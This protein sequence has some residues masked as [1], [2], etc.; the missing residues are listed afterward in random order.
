MRDPHVQSMH[1][2]IGSGEGISYQDPESMT[3]SNH[4]GSFEIT[5]NALSIIP[6]E[7]FDE[8]EEA[9]RAIEPFLRSWE[10]EADLKMNLGMV[11]FSFE[12]VEVIDRDPPP[13]GAPQVI[14]IKAASMLM[15]GSSATLHLTCSKYPP[16]PNS[17][18]STPEVEHA[19]HR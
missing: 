3:F 7:H 13:P 9:R 17:F 14:H 19:Y 10:M 4:L 6:A 1:Y 8:E 12:R 16:P 2:R 15:F 5:G 18:R 11:R